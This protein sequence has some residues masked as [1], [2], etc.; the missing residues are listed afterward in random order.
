MGG[1]MCI[2]TSCMPR[3][4]MEN[5]MDPDSRLLGIPTDQCI[6]FCQGNIFFNNV[7]IF[8]KYLRRLK[9]YNKNKKNKI[10]L[11][12]GLGILGQCSASLL[13]YLPNLTMDLCCTFPRSNQSAD[14][15][16][17][18]CQLIWCGAAVEGGAVSTIFV[19][20]IIVPALHFKL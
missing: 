4:R 10:V 13:D 11:I 17:E 3:F 16:T 5:A 9:K 18:I 7:L 1:R 14:F 12:G 6:L 20:I 15:K 8:F 2:A 19:Q